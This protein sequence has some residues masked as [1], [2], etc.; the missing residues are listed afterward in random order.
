MTNSSYLLIG[1]APKSATTSLYSYLSDHPSI[2]ASS[3]KET[4]FFARS[5]DHQKVC[6]DEETLSAFE[7]Y[8]AHCRDQESLR[9]EATPYTLYSKG[10]AE[11][12]ANLLPNSVLLFI[13]RDPVERLISDYHFAVQRE[14]PSA[15]GTVDD[16][17]EWQRWIKGDTPNLLEMG[18]YARY[19]R[20]YYDVLGPGRSLVIFFEEFIKDPALE[21]KRL[22]SSV[23]IDSAFYT[24]YPFE[25]R[26]R[27]VNVR[28]P[29]LNRM[30][31][32]G[33]I[34]VNSMRAK[35]IHYPIAHRAFESAVK[36]ARSTYF[37]L[38]DKGVVETDTETGRLREELV[39][40]YRPHSKE[41]SEFLGRPLPWK[42]F[43][44][45]Q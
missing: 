34:I 19:I 6:Q 20:R 31:M 1:G 2:C 40:Y 25:T 12:I 11:K 42:S 23:N 41:L 33:E 10:A 18:C 36:M 27:T 30:S 16:F 8:F 17:M 44:D 26:N 28:Y 32:H 37:A 21:M 35:V 22:C 7:G 29:L 15:K 9:I 4:Y 3:R 45:S 43:Q 5:F 13:L 38:N 39:D 24:D 14:H